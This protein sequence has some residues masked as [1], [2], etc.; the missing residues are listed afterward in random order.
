MVGLDADFLNYLDEYFQTL[1]NTEAAFELKR[2]PIFRELSLKQFSFVIIYEESRN[3]IIIYSVFNT[4]Q[5]SNE[6]KK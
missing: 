3:Q 1:I 2:K 6:K 5:T 4:F